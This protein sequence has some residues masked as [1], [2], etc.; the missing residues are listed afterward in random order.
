MKASGHELVTKAIDAFIESG[1]VF[2]FQN[3][4]EFVSAVREFLMSPEREFTHIRPFEEQR[5]RQA[6]RCCWSRVEVAFA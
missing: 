5:A 2:F 1:S 6:Y 4:D 3:E